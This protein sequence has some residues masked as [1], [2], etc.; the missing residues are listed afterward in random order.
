MPVPSTMQDLARL[1]SAN[2]PT[3]SEAI[4]TNLDN[5]LRAQ[6]AILRQTYST[7]SA[8]MA[9]A[10]TV[11][12][13]TADGESVEI[14]GSATINSLGAGFVGCIRELRFD[15]NCTLIHSNNILLPFDASI[16][17]RAGDAL[18]FRCIASGQWILVS[19][20]NSVDLSTLNA[21]IAAA[22][23]AADGLTIVPRVFR[24]TGDGMETDFLME[25]ADVDNAVM[26]SVQVESTDTS[27]LFYALEPF[28]DFTVVPDSDPSNRWLRLQ[29]APANDFDVFVILHGY[30]VPFQN[31][32]GFITTLNIPMF[33]ETDPAFTVDRSYR[34]GMVR[35]NS[36]SP[37]QA[38]IRANTGAEEDW[39]S[40]NFLM[41]LQKSDGLLEV[42]PDTG[43]ILNVPVGFEPKTR[44]KNSVITATCED[45]DT[46]TW[47]LSGDLLRAPSSI[48]FRQSFRLIDR[49]VLFGSNITSSASIPKDIWQPPFD[50]QLDPIDER[51]CFACLH[52]PQSAGNVL[53]VDIKVNG[54]S[55]FSTR[56]TFD[57]SETSTLTAAT[58][59]VYSP[60]FLAANRI[61]PAGSLVEMF[62][63]Q[64]GT[65][66]ARGLSVNL[67]GVRA[68]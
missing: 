31:F 21:A 50:F 66:A 9:A 13:A 54:T 3:G 29:A 63:D 47:T 41:F 26:Y 22:L 8:P 49:V 25:G 46:N 27:R 17:T 68:S 19:N 53:R 67:T 52:V 6:A 39:E 14:T 51:G 43:V 20:S 42:I 32:G 58:P 16:T 48:P 64:L 38:T 45:A 10:S 55:I 35:C 28:V 37:Q 59:A 33:D 24:F 30:A 1:A 5:Y 7:A 57:N 61:I 40:G 62:V 12:I 36:V 15:G 60:T 2:F 56:M 23:G 65:A 34:W 18:V 4:G 44:D 11:D